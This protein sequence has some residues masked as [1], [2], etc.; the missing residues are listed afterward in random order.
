MT[1][2]TYK[3]P[4]TTMIAGE[5]A[6]V[7][8]GGA[9]ACAL[10]SFMY[11][12]WQLKPDSIILSLITSKGCLEY[13]LIDKT[14]FCAR[15][16]AHDPYWN[17]YK[18]LIA[19]LEQTETLIGGLLTVKSDFSQQLGLGS[20]AAFCLGVL[21]SLGCKK[22]Y[23]DKQQ[24]LKLAITAYRK[25]SPM[26]SGTDLAASLYGQLIYFHPESCIV[27]PLPSFTPSCLLAYCGY[28]TPTIEAIGFVKKRLEQDRHANILL[29]SIALISEN[30]AQ[31]LLE[32]RPQKTL[33]DLFQQHQEALEQLNLMTPEL[34]LIAQSLNSDPGLWGVK[35]SGSGLGDSLIAFG[36]QSWEHMFSLPKSFVQ[37]YHVLGQAD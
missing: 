3:Y 26:A 33:R 24:L 15:L 2:M 18:T 36:T 10:K 32:K 4:A 11:F 27:T 25:F 17:L 21:R 20:S 19:T 29:K 7:Y 13:H 34:S 6:V 9:I 8:S 37:E 16:P 5:H 22:L 1:L 12:S 28:K 23:G 14:Y 35:I 30:I 31:T